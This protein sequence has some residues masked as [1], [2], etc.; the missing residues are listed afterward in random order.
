MISQPVVMSAIDLDDPAD[1]A[2]MLKRSGY[3]L[4]SAAAKFADLVD[5]KVEG[6]HLDDKIQSP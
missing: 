5:E 3:L 4:L 1:P 6:S 2:R